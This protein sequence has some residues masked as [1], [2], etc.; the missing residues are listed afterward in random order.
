MR[1]YSKTSILLIEKYM[2]RMKKKQNGFLI[3]LEQGLL[4][5]NPKI[6]WKKNHI[7]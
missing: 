4:I 6:S 7:R 1:E 3:N 5:M 2:T